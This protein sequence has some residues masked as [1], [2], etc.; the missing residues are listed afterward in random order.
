MQ[1]EFCDTINKS[2]TNKE[3]EDENNTNTIS[4]LQSPSMPK[5]SVRPS[6]ASI[7]SNFEERKGGKTRKKS[8]QKANKDDKVSSGQV[9]FTKKRLV[10]KVRPSKDEGTDQPSDD[11]S[12]SADR[13]HHGSIQP[14]IGGLSAFV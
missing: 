3:K 12:A 14:E 10:K 9:V 6:L 11:R 13:N 8:N 2:E 5:D 4:P 1:V 7:N